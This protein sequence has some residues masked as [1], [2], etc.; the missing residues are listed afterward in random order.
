MKYLRVAMVAALLSILCQST[1]AANAVLIVVKDSSGARIACDG[2]IVRHE[3]GRV[4]SFRTDAEG[5]KQFESL[6]EGR[7]RI[8]VTAAGFQMASIDVDVRSGADV[9]RE[10]VLGVIGSNFKIEVTSVLPLP[11][12]GRA[13]DELPAPYQVE[14]AAALHSA[15]NLAD[16]LNRQVRGVHVNEIQGNP[17]QMDVNYRGYTASPL[18]GTPQG[19]SIY[20][21][22]VRMNKPFGDAI[23]WDLIPKN[24]ISEM[25]L[26]PGSNPLFGLNTL[27]GAIAAESK[28]GRRHGGTSLQLSGGS[29]GR[30]MAELEHGGATQQGWHWLLGSSLFFEDGWRESSPSSVRQFYAKGGWQRARTSI[31]VT[32]SFANNSMVGNGL[33][34]Q[35]LLEWDYR[36]IYTKPDIT[37]QKSPFVNVQLRRDLGS[38]WDAAGNVYYRGIPSRVLNGDINEESLDQSLYSLNA[39]EQAAL[40]AAG[41]SGF[42]TSGANA[43]NTPFPFWRCI[44][45]VLLVDE[46]GEKCNG[47]LNRSETLQH[48]YGFTGQ[49]SWRGTAAKTRHQLTMGGAFDGNRVRFLQSSELGYLNPDRSVTGLRVFADGV[50]G[51]EIDGEP[52]DT[53]VNLRSRI[54]AVSAYATDTMSV[55]NRWNFT[56]SGR[57]NRTMIRNRDRILPGG[58]TGSLDGDHNYQRFNPAVGVTTRIAGNATAYASYSEGSRAPT[59]IELGCADP[60]SPCRLPNAL[61]GDPPLNQVVTRTIEFGVRGNVEGNWKWNAGFFRAVNRDDLLFVASPQTGFGYFRNFGRT[62][63]QGFESGLSGQLGRFHAGMNYTYLD[64]TFQS[65][66]EVNGTGNST[67]EEGL[68][69]EGTIDIRP[70]NRI[71]LTPSHIGKGRLDARLTR[72]LNLDLGL[73]VISSSVARGNENNAHQADG[74]F[75]VGRS[76][77]AGYA[78]LNG[79]LRFQLVPRA[80]LFVQAN[81]L[82]DRRFHTAAQLGSTGFTDRGNFIAR[83]FAP[84]NGEYPLVGSTFLAPGAPRGVW[85]GLRIRF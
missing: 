58:G 8:E 72:R 49:L 70:G 37:N 3:T 51:G 68:G 35:R 66:E 36:S 46:P 43:A 33:Q 71:P 41:F 10:I 20:L 23:S 18:L 1:L 21:D 74:R 82:L 60:N 26:A 39:Q 59:A 56:F 63:R 40:R 7:Y 52:F 81:N 5:R 80:E 24:L 9:S 6:A 15:L 61:A 83:P 25:T 69:F 31:S 62:R 2:V 17:F 42:P 64:A 75:Y 53:R 76:N 12:V 44:A 54:Q 78:V 32:T 45:Q 77:S 47:L 48:N 14:S 11:G 65:P 73:V 34:E 27:G 22:G 30:K 13:L 38:R 57:W 28:D 16:F 84:V 85:G 55:G 50:T 67:N 19:I 29:F 79:G 4:D